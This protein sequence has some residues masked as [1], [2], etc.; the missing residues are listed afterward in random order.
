VCKLRWHQVFG[1]EQSADEIMASAE[2]YGMSLSD[3]LRKEYQELCADNPEGWW[4]SNLPDGEMP[5]F[6][7]LARQI[8]RDAED[9]ANDV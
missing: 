8:E 3:W 1:G 9:E 2:Y 5:D 7:E 6:K 4:I